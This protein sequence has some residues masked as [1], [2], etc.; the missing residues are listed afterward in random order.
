M[1]KTAET[2][3]K[4]ED[5]NTCIMLSIPDDFFYYQNLMFYIPGTNFSVM[6]GQLLVFLG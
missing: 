3:Q 4:A 2:L 6:L 1:M 5:S